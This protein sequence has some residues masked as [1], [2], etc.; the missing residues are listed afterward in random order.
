MKAVRTATLLCLA[1]A[2]VTPALAASPAAKHSKPLDIRAFYGEWQGAAEARSE[3]D[4]DFS[5]T[6]RDIAVSMKPTDLGG[7]VLSWSTLQRQKGDPQAPTEVLKSTAV[8]FIPTAEANRWQA[9]TKANVY[10]GGILYWARLDADTLTISTFTIGKDGKPEL[11]TYRRKV[12]ANKMRLEFSNIK[13]GEV[14][15]VVSGNL[16]KTQ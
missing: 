7:F 3:A 15:R 10:E 14:V 12:T 4:E 1:I 6:N 5:T 9:K 2:L 13:D 8:E 11:Q 16:T